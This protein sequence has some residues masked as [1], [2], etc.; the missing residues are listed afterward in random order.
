MVKSNNHIC[1]MRLATLLLLFLFS[2]SVFS[3]SKIQKKQILW[4]GIK[5]ISIGEN[6]SI[7]Y[8]S[9]S[10]CISEGTIKEPP[11]YSEVIPYSGENDAIINIINPVYVE[12]TKE[13]NTIASRYSNSIPEEIISANTNIVYQKKSPY[14]QYS[15]C[16]FKINKATGKYERLSEFSIE[17][18]YTKKLAKPSI[19]DKKYVSNSVLSSGSW[20]KLSVN[21]SGVYQLTYN[22]LI[23]MGVDPASINPQDIKIYGNGGGML[24]ENNADS[25]IDDLFENAIFVSGESDGKF[26]PSDYILF[27]GEGPVKWSYNSTDKRF[28]HQTNYYS[29]S[30]SYFFTVGTSS[31][32]RIQNQNSV[33]EA[34]TISVT[35]FD[36]YQCHE[37][38]SVNLVLSGKEWYGENFDILT[39]YSFKFNFPNIDATSK[40]YVKYDIAARNT[41]TSYFKVNANGYTMTSM[42]GAYSG[43]YQYA[44]D[45]SDTLSFNSSNPEIS[46]S[47]TKNT[48]NAIGW[49]NYIE[50]N[51]PRNLSL[52]GNQ[53]IFRNVNC[54]GPGNISDFIVSNVNSNAT[55]WEISNPL[56]PKKQEGTLNGS[57]FQF[58]LP[59]DSLREFV[60]FSN[61]GYLIPT[62]SGTVENQNL[63]ALS[64]TDFIIVS[65][66]DFVSEAN[67]L[68]SL[69]YSHNNYSY[70]IVT[71][72][73]IYNEFSSG[74]QDPAAI[75]DF[76]K[77]FYD[78]APTIDEQPK[79]LL[80]FGDASFDYKNRIPKNTN[81]VPTF[82]SPYALD[83]T[84]SYAT[85]DFFGL[86]D[87][88]EGPYLP[89]L[90]DIG[91]GRFP[92]K[93]LGEA[94]AMVDK[95]VRYI[96]HL[97]P[98]T[99][100]EG[101]STNNVF[102][103]G[104]WRNAI[105][106]VADDEEWGSFLNSADDLAKYIDTTYNNYNIE[107]IYS[108]SYVQQTGAGG[109][110][111][112]DV[113]LALNKRVEKGALIINY[114]GHG[115]E[116]GWALERILEVSDIKGWKNLYNMPLFVTATCEFSRF[117]DP[118][119]T[120]AGEFVL[121]NE[122]G[123]GIGLFTTS[124]IAWS[125]SNETL[126]RRFYQYSLKKKDSAYPTL[127]EL[128]M[129]SKNS[130]GG[131]DPNIKNFVLLGDPALML[132]YPE[133]AVVTTTIDQHS[134]GTIT[135][136]LKAFD[137][138][139]IS[140]EIHDQ[141][142]QK[143]TSFNGITFP[144]V[145]DKKST[146]STLGND[147][148]SP[149]IAYTIQKSILY[150]GKVSVVN[151][152]FSFSFIVPKDIAYNYGI[153]RI[154]YYAEDG[155]T[156]ASGY[157]E[158]DKFIIGG[159]GNNFTN[160]ANGPGVRLFLNDSAFANNG[161]TD[162]NPVLLAYIKD[163]SG[164]NTVDNG[165]G[166]EI[167]AILD[168][169][170]VNPIIL[171]DYYQANLNSFQSGSVRYKFE[172]LENG[173]HSVKF[174]VWDIYNNSSEVTVDFVVQK[175]DGL[176][177][178][179][180]FNYPNPFTTHTK[181]FFEH[182]QPC[183]ALNVQIQI[184]TITGKLIKTI[185]Q[186]V[187]TM[188]YRAEPIDWDGLDEYGD[189][190]GKGVYLYKLKVKNNEGFNAEKTEKLVI[191]K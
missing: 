171:N 3:Q 180:V 103:P 90:L 76:V 98:N 89:S 94:S 40:T 5:T 190:V 167:T 95:V 77:M 39:S 139:T 28:H 30:T 9:F 161:I 129:L 52:S 147:P 1:F 156:D 131:I 75:R 24:P 112:P 154:S 21:T 177:L 123:G 26:D 87:N 13:E 88:N 149:V 97:N 91:T 115:G 133:N 173:P 7:K 155:A 33:S 187:E 146:T 163:S 62:K 160:D 82:Q 132:N 102:A 78:N 59:T 106:F 168:G 84:D 37:K 58:R 56:Q 118:N 157:Y 172:N 128:V 38:D 124:R 110:R 113:N 184:F 178:A 57:N 134:A 158:N 126:N 108:D 31:G 142:G 41:S 53:T 183:C 16:P 51:A 150:K 119:R 48:A 49:L 114:I 83:Y 185:N 2:N 121:L 68:A 143:L 80:L 164:I 148:A 34:A 85:D 153:G 120:S 92:V 179:H 74:N 23:E 181:F 72:Q 69:H 116:V 12:M 111:Y 96:T 130:L 170:T 47:V 176:T 79:F 81:Y 65:H 151:G 137:K 6:D 17:V 127:G 4:E 71:P 22:D 73:K 46:I 50:V 29:E 93:T 174:R 186:E 169:N 140:G 166:H 138:V 45:T 100:T 135:D 191:I 165:I 66:P 104:D 54:V 36:D 43:T 117:D 32:K 61:S 159:L 109:Q 14:L 122:T 8:L 42:I 35:K 67:R 10:N 182:N 125:G 105:C 152:D 162:E 86:L 99:V 136:T 188:G 44:R 60:V 18:S 145:Y 15:F 20:Y 63:H 64:A 175:A 19:K 144:T 11:L 141:N 55:I 25:R 101:C 27:Y 70:V 189:Y 107:K